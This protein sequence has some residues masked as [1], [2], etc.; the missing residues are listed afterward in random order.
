MHVLAAIPMLLAALQ[1]CCSQWFYQGKLQD[2]VSA[3]Q[4]PPAA[5]FPWPSAG[6]TSPVA[7][8]QVAGREER[9]SRKDRQRGGASSSS[10]DSE[11]SGAQADTL[12]MAMLDGCTCTY[13]KWCISGI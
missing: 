13:C 8:V 4:K 3:Q 10:S 2:G 1:W 5:G 7:L 11:V 6:G 12:E 9:A